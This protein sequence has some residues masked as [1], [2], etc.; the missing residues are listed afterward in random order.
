MF[1]PLLSS[2]SI[3]FLLASAVEASTFSSLDQA[4]MWQTM[5]A[6]GAIGDWLNYPFQ[7]LSLVQMQKTFPKAGKYA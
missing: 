2:S 4:H 1:K 6:L 7:S 3:I 5:S